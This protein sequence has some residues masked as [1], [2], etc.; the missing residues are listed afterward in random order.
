MTRHACNK[1]GLADPRIIILTLFGAII[2]S[3]RTFAAS[4]ERVLTA[5]TQPLPES[6]DLRPIFKNWGLT[7]RPQGTR[8]TCSICTVTDAIEYALSTQQR[9]GIRL[10]AEFLNWAKNQTTGNNVD[11]GFF[12]R[13][14]ERLQPIWNLHHR[15]NAV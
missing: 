9:S 4:P 12:L 7:V 8:N 3:V 2:M 13:Y 10:S 11:G 1:K 15:Q 6:I 14:V 5:T